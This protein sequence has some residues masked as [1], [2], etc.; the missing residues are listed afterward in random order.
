MLA[1]FK[2]LKVESERHDGVIIITVEGEIDVYNSWN[3]KEVLLMATHK[4]FKVMVVNMRKVSFIDS[5]GLGVLVSSLKNVRSYGGK[6]KL[7]IINDDINKIFQ[8]TSLDTLFE[9]YPTIE[10]TLESI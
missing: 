10:K 2:Q 4:R 9:I 1:P 3:F 6:I 8:V 7:V 5:T